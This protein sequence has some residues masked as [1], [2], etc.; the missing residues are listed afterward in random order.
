MTPWGQLGRLRQTLLVLLASFLALTALGLAY[1]NTR[2]GIGFGGFLLRT[3]T[4]DTTRYEGKVM[5]RP[6]TIVVTKDQVEIDVERTHYGPYTLRED[7]TAVPAQ[8]DWDGVT[9][10]QLR[11]IELLEG[12]KILFRGGVYHI[13]DTWRLF[14]EDGTYRQ[15]GTYGDRGIPTPTGICRLWLGPQLSHLGS[16]LGLAL[17]GLLALLSGAAM[18]FYEYW[19]KWSV[20]R[21]VRNVED[22]EPTDRELFWAGASWVVYT[23]LCG[24]LCVIALRA[25]VS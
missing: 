22:P 20:Q 7:P 9:G 23:G 24:Y 3:Q 19:F 17:A 18:L 14:D 8:T 25:P 10:E 1:Q 4:G 21:S 12:E 6:V 15:E 13:G 11:G 5:D 16:W 2:L